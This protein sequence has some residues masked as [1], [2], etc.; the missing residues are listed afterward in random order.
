[1]FYF[2]LVVIMYFL[3]FDLVTIPTYISLVLFFIFVVINL[4][5]KWNYEI[6]KIPKRVNVGAITH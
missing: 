6:A 2:I 1:M 4:Y 3:V 5:R